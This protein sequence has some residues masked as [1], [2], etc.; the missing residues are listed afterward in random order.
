MLESKTSDSA[1]RM[2]G[3]AVDRIAREG[4]TVGLD[5]LRMEKVIKEAGV[6][7]AT[8]YRRWPSRDQFVADV[9]VEVVRRTSLIPE[10]P[11][12]LRRLVELVE[13]H[14]EGLLTT[15]GRRA[16]VVEALRVSVDSDVRRLLDS[17]QVRTFISLSAT[18][19]GLPDGAVRD[20]V[21][22][23]LRDTEQSFIRRRSE[24]YAN[25]A[26]LVGY[27]LRPGSAG[28][29]ALASAAGLMMTG[30]LVRALPDR[31]W[32]DERVEAAPFGGAA[33]SWS[34]PERLLV[35]LLLTEIEPDPALEWDVDTIDQFR[36]RFE[37]QVGEML[38]IG[39]AHV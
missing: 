4:M 6:S 8:A 9:L 2:L 34:E 39:R 13:T 22:S 14:A 3:V 35:G 25:L 11:D 24:V 38:E 27:R 7:R 12:D 29:D 16:L 37:Q 20:A 15:D 31:A 23:A 21:G 5:G 1:A 17:P 28:L 18:Y 32:L 10:R 30:I 19:Q 33:A 36:E 26:A